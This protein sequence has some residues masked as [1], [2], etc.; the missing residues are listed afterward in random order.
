MDTIEEGSC[1]RHPPKIWVLLSRWPTLT[2]D[3]S[4]IEQEVTCDIPRGPSI[5][6]CHSARDPRRWRSRVRGGKRA[7]ATM[8]E[9]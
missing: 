3:M 8:T 6:T 2:C 5:D 1:N 9:T 7:R 4:V